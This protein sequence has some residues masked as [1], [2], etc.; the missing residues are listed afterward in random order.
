[1]AEP[2][3]PRTQPERLPELVESQ[4]MS[5]PEPPRP[6][7]EGVHPGLVPPPG[8]LPIGFGPSPALIWLVRIGVVGLATWGAYWAF[9]R[10][11]HGVGGALSIV[12]IIGPALA[13]GYFLARRVALLRRHS[14][15]KGDAIV[16]A[17]VR[18]EAAGILVMSW[19]W[20]HRFAWGELIG[21]VE[22]RPERGGYALRA[23]RASRRVEILLPSSGWG[24]R[25]ALSLSGRPEHDAD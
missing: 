1:M 12:D 15:K 7:D 24:R 17:G 19:L 21:I 3:D 2:Q 10:F 23:L 22:E 8:A 13:V 4:A 6:V 11:V 18:V 25:L 16:A 9:N 20:D 14:G 5:V